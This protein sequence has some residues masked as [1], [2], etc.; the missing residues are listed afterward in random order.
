MKIAVIG[1]GIAGVATAHE[2]AALGHEVTVFEHKASVAAE[3]SFA[4]PGWL[5][6]TSPLPWAAPGMR[7]RRGRAWLSRQGDLHAPL[8]SVLPLAGRLLR[9]ARAHQVGSPAFAQRQA[10]LQALARLSW[11]RLGQLTQAHGLSYERREGGLLLLSTAQQLAAAQAALDKA[12]P[13]LAA[14]GWELLSAA[15]ARVL[16]PDL[17][18][19]WPLRAALRMPRM[20][21]GNARLLAQGLKAL[22]Q[23]QGAVFRFGARVQALRAAGQGGAAALQLAGAQDWLNYEQIVLCAGSESEPLLRRAGLKLRLLA[24]WSYALTA[25]LR[26]VEG[27]GMR[28]PVAGVIDAASGI[29][30]ARLGQRLRVTGLQQLGG[31]LAQI[32]PSIARRLFA[33]LERSYPGCAV[34]REAALWKGQRPRATDGLPMVG[35]AL[36]GLWLNTGHGAHGWALACGAAQALASSL[37]QQDAPIALD[38]FAPARRR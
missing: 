6:A 14:A 20:A 7:R 9:Q 4:L 31:S 28:G 29:A 5:A 22:A 11:D 36:P 3:G 23:Q 10:A 25:P 33:A 24:P 34:L 21:V 2:L 37:T 27:L 8:A 18:D 32:D 17:A 19:S 35:S 26:H 38:A 30:I 16:E 12:G 1:A 15:Q 13:E